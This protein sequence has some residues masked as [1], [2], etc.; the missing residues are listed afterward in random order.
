[1]LPTYSRWAC[2]EQL[3]LG[4]YHP[5]AGADPIG[6]DHVARRGSA[7]VRFGGLPAGH[8]PMLV[9]APAS[10]A[11]DTTTPASGRPSRRR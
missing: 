1:M 7:G 8:A 3:A 10:T 9:V 5:A 6:G 11:G 4:G 2:G